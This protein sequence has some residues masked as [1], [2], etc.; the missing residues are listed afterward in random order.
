MFRLA[1]CRS[2]MVGSYQEPHLAE[3]QTPVGGGAEWIR[4]RPRGSSRS[5][6]RSLPV[7]TSFSRAEVLLLR[8][9]TPIQQIVYHMM[10]FIA[11]QEFIKTDCKG[12]DRIICTYHIKTLMMWACEL[13]S[14][15][16]WESTGVV[17]ICW[18][19]LKS[20]LRW[21]R[22]KICPHYFIPEW[23][24]FGHQMTRSKFE[25]TVEV[26]QFFCNRKHLS[27]WFKHNY[28]LKIVKQMMEFYGN[29]VILNHQTLQQ[30]ILTREEMN[31]GDIVGVAFE[32]HYNRIF[33][34]HQQ[35]YKLIVSEKVK[36]SKYQMLEFALGCLR[37]AWNISFHEQIELSNAEILNI[38]SAL[39][40]KLSN[41][42][43]N[44][45][46]TSYNLPPFVVSKWYFL[47]GVTV[48]S[49]SCAKY[50][51][52]HHI[53]KKTC[54]RYFKSALSIQYEYSE[55]I[56]NACHSYLAALYYASDVIHSEKANMHC[57]RAAIP[58]SSGNR[59]RIHTLACPSLLF[60]DEMAAV[61]GFFVIFKIVYQEA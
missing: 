49:L 54:K 23:N 1:S 13:K 26:M 34:G 5:Q 16:W 31:S 12:A 4:C 36:P 52:G 56:H 61:C 11:K 2:I 51:V 48:L 21:I 18:E 8:S 20:L 53:W 55:S 19:L 59:L 29:P 39:I 24:L 9:W 33:W 22:E 7:E 46:S 35:I 32:Y 17:G 14:P 41:F 42:N 60:V 44:C 50:S 45:V 30:Y 58:S 40:S 47:R 43:S 28:V 38:L 3:H 6:A 10:R 15:V 57:I 37:L 27:E 25:D